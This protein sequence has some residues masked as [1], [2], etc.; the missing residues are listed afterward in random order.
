MSTRLAYELVTVTRAGASRSHAY[1]P[2][3][4]LRP[5]GSRPRRGGACGRPCSAPGGLGLCG[6]RCD[7]GRIA[8]RA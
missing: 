2:E 3:T 8:A 1:S 6:C 4:E 7:R 5:A